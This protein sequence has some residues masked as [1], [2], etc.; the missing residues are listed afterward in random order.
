M[1]PLDTLVVDDEA[2][3]RFFL[4]ETL[5]RDGHSVAT[6]ESGEVALDL[7]RDTPFDLLILDLNLGGRI[8][9]MKILEAVRWRWPDTVVIILTAHGSLETAMR[10]INDRVDRYLLKPTT[11]TELRV[12]IQ[13][14]LAARKARHERIDAL[15]QTQAHEGILQV[16]PFDVDLERRVVTYEGAVRELGPSEFDLLV[17]LMRNSERVVPPREL[18]EAVRGYRPD[19]LYEARNIIKWYVHRLRQ[20]VEP[21]PANPRFI[22]NIRGVGY[23][24]GD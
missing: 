3:I 9:G 11:P 24:F 23:R 7:L 2:G 13:E 16:G 15:K 12:A 4:Q 1:E 8:D 10:A 21:D 19:D 14:S 20:S 5:Q 17:H 22:V 6:A 18:V